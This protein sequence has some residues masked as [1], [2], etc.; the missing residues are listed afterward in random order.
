MLEMCAN[1]GIC[2]GTCKRAR[3]SE[4]VKR[5][6]RSAATYRPEETLEPSRFYQDHHLIYSP[7]KT[8]G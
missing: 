5:P 1:T 4:G 2:R 6:G 8:P 3:Y 7:L